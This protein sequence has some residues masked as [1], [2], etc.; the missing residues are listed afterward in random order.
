MA[1]IKKLASWTNVGEAGSRAQ[2]FEFQLQSFGEVFPIQVTWLG[3]SELLWFISSLCDL[4][5]GIVCVT[6]ARE[7][8]GVAVLV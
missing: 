6:R 4:E 2:A 3:H 7:R 8:A 5:H 1:F